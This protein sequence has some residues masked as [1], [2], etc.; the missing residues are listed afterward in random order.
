MRPREGGLRRGETFWFRLTTAS[1]QYLRLAER[2]FHYELQKNI[3]WQLADMNRPVEKA[4]TVN[5]D[6]SAYKSASVDISS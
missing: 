5:A 4:A 1:A 2:F 3:G 6:M